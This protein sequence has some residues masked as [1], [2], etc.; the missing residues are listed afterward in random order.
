MCSQIGNLSI[1]RSFRK[2]F[3]KMTSSTFEEDFAVFEDKVDEVMQILNLMSSDDKK[4]SE[5]GVEIAN[6]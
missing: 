6:K 4:A 2:H 3:K 1:F 5:Q